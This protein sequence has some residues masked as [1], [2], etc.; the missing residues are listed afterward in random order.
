MIDSVVAPVR[1]METRTESKNDTIS[2][3]ERDLPV[4]AP[5][6]KG[7]EILL[8]KTSVVMKSDRSEAFSVISNKYDIHI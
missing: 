5:V 6:C 7:V 8:E 1:G 3:I 2:L 4:I